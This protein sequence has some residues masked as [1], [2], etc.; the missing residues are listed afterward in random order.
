[1]ILIARPELLVKSGVGWGKAAEDCRTTG[2][3]AQ[4]P[5]MGSR[6]VDC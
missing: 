2:R 1:M 4:G 3:F 5:G 6:P